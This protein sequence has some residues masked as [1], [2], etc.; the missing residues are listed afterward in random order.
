M[1]GTQ[2]TTTHQS[3]MQLQVLNQSYKFPSHKQLHELALNNNNKIKESTFFLSKNN[4][5][6]PSFSKLLKKDQPI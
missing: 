4:L 3:F 5:E 1:L 2:P 6:D